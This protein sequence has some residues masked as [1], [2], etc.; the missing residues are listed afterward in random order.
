MVRNA[1]TGQDRTFRVASAPVSTSSQ[2]VGAVTIATDV[3]E[4]R[5]REEVH[6]RLYS[7][8]QRAVAD[9]EHALAVVSHDLRSPLNTI[10]MSAEILAEHDPDAATA[11]KAAL[12][13]RRA[14][15]RMN[16]MISDLLDFSSIQ[17]GRLSVTLQPIDVAAVVEEAADAARGEAQARGLGLRVEAA[18]LL[19]RA[20]RDRLVQAL[21]NLLGNA[22]KATLEGEV[23]VKVEQQD[24]TVLFSVSDT[25][26]GIPR[27]VQ[28][29]LFEPYWRGNDPSYKGTGLGLTI[30]SGIVEAHGGRIWAESREGAGATFSFTI[31]MGAPVPHV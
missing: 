14:V 6:R 22:I 1:R 15:D 23:T 13:I 24:G 21:S 5:E 8:A 10:R 18:P 9:R 4:R 11:R 26:P 25:G 29:H 2:V 19:V 27:E 12:T 16:R 7:Q 31:P 3:T 20:D 30:T 17:A 28:S